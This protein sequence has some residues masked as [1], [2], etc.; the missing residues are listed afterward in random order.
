MAQQ[1]PLL[2]R[3]V[4]TTV[5]RIN[6]L[7]VIAG[8]IAYL[9][10]GI[11]AIVMLVIIDFLLRLYGYKHISPTQNVSLWIQRKF[12]LPVKME[13]A[14]AKRLAAYFGVGFMGAIVVL[15][16]LGIGWAVHAVTA[17]YLACAFLDLFFGF[18]I[19]CK[20]YYMV[21]KIYPQ[22]FA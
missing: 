13:D 11:A 17:L 3:Q 6:T 12:S 19:A 18:C 9:L 16:W 8:V 20:I 22:G 10:S 2:F 4:D 1:C 21:K 7:F 5:I 14:G 15:H